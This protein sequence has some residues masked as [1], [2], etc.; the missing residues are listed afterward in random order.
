MAKKIFDDKTHLYQI[1]T[2]AILSEFWQFFTI[3]QGNSIEFWECPSQLKWRLHRSVDKDLKLFNPQ[4]ILLNK[5]SCDY[6][7]KFDNNN[8]TNLWKITFQAL[9][10][11][12]RHFLDLVNHNFKDIKL[13]YIKGGLWLQS[14]GHSNSLCTRATRAIT[15]HALIGEYCLRFFS[16]EDF[17]CPCGSYP[18]ETR[19]HILHEC[20]RHNRYW[21]PK[22]DSL[23]H[24]VMF[25][26]VNPKA[27]TFIDN[28]LSVTPS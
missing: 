12:G 18:I 1:H 17:K 4:P 13:S 15:N 23:S 2:V 24:F 20:T 25:L 8:I 27:F 28:V 10:G 26:S 21:N 3:G 9:D 16:N 19:R 6:C 11:K 22:R 5:V 14:F 7:K